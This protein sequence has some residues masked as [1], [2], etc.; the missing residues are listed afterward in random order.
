VRVSLAQRQGRVVLEVI[1]GGT[2]FDPAERGT[3]V[4]LASMRERAA[5]AGGSL[6][7]SS[8]PGKGTRVRL[9]VPMT[10]PRRAASP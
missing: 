7:I 5:Q 9:S 2:G 4:G 1:D 10:A 3:G 8:A 6:V